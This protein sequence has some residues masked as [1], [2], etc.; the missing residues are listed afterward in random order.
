MPL[1]LYDF[2]AAPSP[3]RA[4]IFLHEKGIDYTCIQVNLGSGEQ[5]S[6]AYRRINPS[7]TVPALILDDG[8]MLNQNAAIA[9]YLE[10]AFPEPALFGRT[11][12]EL[13]RV[14]NAAVQ[15]EMG[16]LM[17]VAEALRNSSPRM[18]DR[19]LPGPESYAQIPE[20]A[21]RGRAR[22]GQFMQSLDEQL[23]G[24]EFLAIDTF[25]YADITAWVTVDFV[26]WVKVTPKETQPN[27]Q[28]WYH[29]LAG[30]ASIKAARA[31]A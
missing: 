30:R 9:H 1:T 26:K 25:S 18:K 12:E 7:C 24:R 23:A 14:V 22:L 21:E 5:L 4:R 15:A 20:L 16:G 31:S 6:E 11:P 29:A 3:L 19:A 13:G 28:R 27:L 17:A 10:A 8:T 2:A